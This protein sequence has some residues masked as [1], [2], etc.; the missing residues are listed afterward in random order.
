MKKLVTLI[1]RNHSFVVTD[2]KSDIVYN[3]MNGVNRKLTTYT[4]EYNH[5]L[6]KRV[7]VPS[8]RYYVSLEHIDTYIYSI[9]TFKY[10]VSRLYSYGLVKDEIDIVDSR[11]YKY[12]KL[13]LKFNKDFKL[14]EN[15]IPYIEAILPYAPSKLIDARTGIG[16]SLMA[17][18]IVHKLNMKVFILILPKYIQKWIDDVKLY[19]PNIKDDDIYVIRG[20]DSLANLIE[21]KQ[22]YKIIIASVRTMVNYIKDFEKEE[23]MYSVEPINLM[24]HLKVGIVLNDES[25]QEYHAVFR[26]MMY[27]NAHRLLGLS[28]TLVSDDYTTNKMYSLLYPEKYRASNLVKIK[29]Y[30]IV[31]S[32]RYRIESVSR[33]NYL[34]P[35]GYNHIKLEQSIMRNSTLLKYYL[36]MIDYYVQNEYIKH[37]VVKDNDKLLIFCASI[38]M[39]TLVANHYSKK[40]NDLDVRRYVEDDPYENLLE[41]DICVSTHNSAGTAVDIPNLITVIQTVSIGSMQAN[42]Q[43]MGRLREI[44][45]K[46]VRYV[47]LYSPDIEPHINLETKRR[48]AIETYAKSYEYSEYPKVLKVM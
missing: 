22:K 29:K 27:F 16:K 48:N 4:F 25:H 19:Y 11:E 20:G 47:Y 43:N 23:F 35:Q 37:R 24:E 45:G 33:L 30:T 18:Y 38:N 2:I 17:S 7:R 12:D 41:A 21:S 14:R 39:C 34:S 28:A 1:I 10:F 26:C 3:V 44:K 40:Y 36:E 8:R 15:Q 5:K 13:N 32:I 31:K 9:N 46:E 6:R 42:I